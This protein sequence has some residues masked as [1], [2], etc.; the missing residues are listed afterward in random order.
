[1]LREMNKKFAKRLAEY[2]EL[3]KFEH[4]IFALPFALAAM[5]LAK[6]YGQWPSWQTAWWILL[7]MVG[8][9]T[10]AMGLNRLIDAEIDGKNPRTA[11][12]SLPA[13]RVSKAGALTLALGSALL[14]IGSTLQLPLICQQLL[15][16]AFMLLTIYSYMKLFSPMAHLVLGLALGSSAVGGWLAVTGALAWPP[17]L[18]GFAVVFWV[19]GFD[20]IYA[21][22][23][24]DFDRQAGL[25]SIPVVLGL[26][27]ALLTSRI[28]H[29]LTIVLLI[30]FCLIYPTGPL[31]KGAIILMACMLIY[32]H[33]LVQGTDTQPINLANVNE[34]FFNVNGRISLSIFF[35][36]LADKLL[37]TVH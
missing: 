11:N 36:V 23:D 29:I 17:V 15:P 6:P 34:A 7:C 21:C 5:L 8:G 2:A 22:Q 32:E 10:Y 1:M 13:G 24:Y 28:F 35:L 20:I 16:L 33:R 27:G 25:K 9:R 26:K 3:V 19:A 31:F 14:L 4:T 30:G 12:R 18:F 37:A